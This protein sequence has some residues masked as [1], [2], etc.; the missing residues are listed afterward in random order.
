MQR[1]NAM[2]L[3]LMTW[4]EVEGY[5]ESSTGIMMPI[6]S[7]EQH[8]PNG[9]IGTD[10]ICAEA[11]AL[12]AGQ[13]AGAAVGPTI[14]VGMA[15]H[16]MA[17]AGSMTL[18]PTTL[19]AVIVDYVVSLARHGFRRFYFVNGH[20]GNISTVQTAFQEI[21]ARSSLADG[22]DLPAIRCVL[23]NWYQ[24]P[25]VQALA[26]DL[27]GTREGYHA[28]PSEISVTQHVH[29]EAVRAVEMPPATGGGFDFTDAADFR[30]RFP[31]GRMGSDPSLATPEHG[32]RLLELAAEDLA[33]DYVA[34]V[35]DA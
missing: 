27:F 24:R 17:F 7:T 4:P 21:Y 22:D 9:M 20:G 31:D 25:R 28:T 34:F 10:A 35:R 2:R 15:Q 11:I 3:H 12:A 18:R 33:D 1:E 26:R 16:H 29:A 5:L 19:V 6:G 32:R 14:G 13:R 23:R 30:R 8:G